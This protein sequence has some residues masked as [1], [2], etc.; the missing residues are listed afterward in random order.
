MAKLK[1]LLEVV[2]LVGLAVG[3]E[4]GEKES[5]TT[6]SSI[7]SLVEKGKPVATI[8]IGEGASKIEEHAAKELQSYIHKISGAKL[9]IKEDNEEIKGNKILIDNNRLTT[10]LKI[11]VSSL[12]KEGFIIKRV[13]GDLI[14]AGGGPLGTLYSVYDLLERLGCRFFTPDD[15]VIPELKDIEVKEINIVEEPDFEIRWVGTSNWSIKNKLN[16]RLGKVE[17]E[18]IG[19][20]LHSCHTFGRLLPVDKYYEQHPEFYALVNG[21]RKGGHKDLVQLCLS[22]PE[23]VKEVANNLKDIFAKNPDLGSYLLMPGDGHAFCECPNCKALDD[24]SYQHE[25]PFI[26][27]DT[28]KISNRLMIFYNQVAKEIYKTYPNKIIDIGAYDIYIDP[29]GGIKPYKNIRV[30][31][32]HFSY[33]STHSINDPDCKRNQKFRKTLEKWLSISPQGVWF[34]EY[35][36]KTSWRSLFWPIIHTI[37]EDIPYFKRLGVKGLV[38]Q[39]SH[40][41]VTQGPIYYITAKLLWDAES[42]VAGLLD[43]Y[44]SKFYGNAGQAIKRIFSTLETRMQNSECIPGDAFGNALKLF[45]PEVIAKCKGYLKEAEGLADNEIIKKRVEKMNIAFTYNE[46]FVE[47]LRLESLSPK[48]KTSEEQKGILSEAISY[49]EKALEIARANKSFFP[50]PKYY[51]AHIERRIKKLR[52][53]VSSELSKEELFKLTF[54]PPD[55]NTVLL[56]HFDE[57][58]GK[59]A[60]DSSNYG[61]N[62]IL[63]GK[64]TDSDWISGKFGNALHFDGIN[65][66][67]NCGNNAILA[68]SQF[69]IEGWIKKGTN[70]DMDIAK[71]WSASKNERSWSLSLSR[72]GTI[73][74]VVSCDGTYNRGQYLSFSCPFK[75]GLDWTHFAVTY[76]GSEIKIYINGKLRSSTPWAKGVYG[77]E[78]NLEI[79]RGIIF[80]KN[81]NGLIDEFRISNKA[82]NFE[83]MAIFYFEEKMGSLK[84]EIFSEI[85]GRIPSL[86]EEEGIIYVKQ[87]SFHPAH[88][89]PLRLYLNNNAVIVQKED[90]SRMM[91]KYFTFKEKYIQKADIT[92]P[93]SPYISISFLKEIKRKSIYTKVQGKKGGAC[94]LYIVLPKGI[95]IG[96]IK[97][98]QWEEGVGQDYVKIDKIRDRHLLYLRLEWGSGQDICIAELK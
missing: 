82:I 43:D 21:K 86:K 76:A 93:S 4:A 23:V 31:L 58:K 64:M 67:V 35:Y 40:T 2:L 11:D 30:L 80:G 88:K 90:Y 79:G 91:S 54:R 98:E 77:G 65:N 85:A 41:W 10:E 25:G 1:K 28:G 95:N 45:T 14:L 7:Y 56:L 36:W 71:K 73:G 92:I 50:P 63:K 62:G 46:A 68:T 57:S 42:D 59:T 39:C 83:E 89:D 75:I 60:K 26:G 38:T 5:L 70:A 72:G 87:Q 47:A 49:W 22:N 66:F 61:N 15:E 13:K 16:V 48:A 94:A 20:S 32:S 84:K 33:C 78:A 37:K 51:E 18:S 52:K 96:K 44:F 74:G 24:P 12:H 3:L 29:P 6:P 17:G 27:R 81:F 97:T 9:P 34:Y 19:K 55:D 69:T 8:V 53:L